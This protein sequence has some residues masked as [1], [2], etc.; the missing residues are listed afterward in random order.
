MLFPLDYYSRELVGK[1]KRIKHVLKER[2]LWLERGLVLECL[3][4]HNISGCAPEDGYCARQ[5]LGVGRG[6]GC[7]CVI[8]YLISRYLKVSGG[9]S[10]T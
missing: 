5:V 10:L 9:F 8:L 3:T 7:V 2:G 4:P 6:C 1:P